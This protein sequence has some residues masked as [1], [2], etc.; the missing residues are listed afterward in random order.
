MDYANFLD[1][2][3]SL[4]ILL[5]LIIG[6]ADFIKASSKYPLIIKALNKIIKL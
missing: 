1:I 6:L 4:L 2:A 3:I 5:F